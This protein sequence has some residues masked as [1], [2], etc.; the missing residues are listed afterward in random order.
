MIYKDST[1]KLNVGWSAFEDWFQQ[2]PFAT[3]AGIKQLCRDSYAAGMGDPLVTYAQPAPKQEPFCW[4]YYERGEEMFAPPD[5][6]RPDDA[7]PLFL[8]PPQAQPVKP[9]KTYQ[10]KCEDCG[11]T[12]EQQ[13][14]CWCQEAKFKER[15]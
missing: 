12:D 8:A 2:Q 1:P 6:Y 3:Q 15:P 14:A 11:L 7:Q 4:L 13:N 5:G 10:Y 9:P